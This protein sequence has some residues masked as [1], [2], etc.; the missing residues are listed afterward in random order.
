[1][2]ELMATPHA[3]PQS[4]E[5]GGSPVKFLKDSLEVGLD[6]KIPGLTREGLETEEVWEGYQSGGR[7]TKIGRRDT[8]GTRGL[9]WAA[10]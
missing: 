10:R 8:G 4:V 2:G 9:H 6:E 1:M 5:Q 3:S 7:A